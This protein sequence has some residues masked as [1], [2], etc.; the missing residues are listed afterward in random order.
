M[1]HIAAV[2]GGAAAAVM[3]A[4]AKVLNDNPEDAKTKGLACGLYIVGTCL[5]LWAAAET[6]VLDSAAD[7]AGSAA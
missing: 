2:L 4:G 6:G 3:L 7:A 1:K 5:A